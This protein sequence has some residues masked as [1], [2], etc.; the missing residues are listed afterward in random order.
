MPHEIVFSF[1]L[2]TA[3]RTAEKFIK[4]MPQ[5]QTRVVEI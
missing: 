1:F 2:E 4:V 5:N 3:R